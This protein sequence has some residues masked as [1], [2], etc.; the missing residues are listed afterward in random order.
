MS[1]A[2]SLGRIVRELDVHVFLK[3]QKKMVS[4]REISKVLSLGVHQMDWVELI[5]D[6]DEEESAMEQIG[7][8]LCNE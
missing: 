6:G 8:L 7:K 2:V 5:V 1:V 4:A 3:S